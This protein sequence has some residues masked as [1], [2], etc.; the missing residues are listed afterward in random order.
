MTNEEMDIIANR[1]AQKFV[2]QGYNQAIEDVE[3]WWDGKLG[4]RGCKD[5]YPVVREILK[6]LSY[7]KKK[8]FHPELLKKC[9]NCRWSPKCEG[10]QDDNGEDCFR[11]LLKNLDPPIKP[12]EWPDRGRTRELLK[13]LKDMIDKTIEDRRL[14]IYRCRMMDMETQEDET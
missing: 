12:L 11:Y 9:S 10:D 2:E 7:K 13:Q 14:L 6:K 5:F 4:E 1:L 3:W 8:R